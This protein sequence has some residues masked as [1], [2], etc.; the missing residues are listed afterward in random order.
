MSDLCTLY[1]LGSP[2]RLLASCISIQSPFSLH[3]CHPPGLARESGK[4]ALLH[5]H[6]CSH[7]GGDVQLLHV[8]YNFHSAA[9]SETQETAN[10]LR[11]AELLREVLCPFIQQVCVWMSHWSSFPVCSTNSYSINQ[12]ACLFLPA[13]C[14]VLLHEYTTF[15]CREEVSSAQFYNA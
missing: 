15:R 13:Q 5:V 1:T 9:C 3:P 4:N 12:I 2:I 6:K 8:V 11:L 14:T 10:C 7:A